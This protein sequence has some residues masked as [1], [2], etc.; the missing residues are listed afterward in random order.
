MNKITIETYLNSLGSTL[1]DNGAEAKIDVL[2][3]AALMLGFNAWSDCGDVDASWEPDAIFDI[4]PAMAYSGGPAGWL[5][6]SVSNIILP[7][8]QWG[9]ALKYGGLTVRLPTAAFCAAMLYSKLTYEPEYSDDSRWPLGKAALQIACLCH[10]M[11]WSVDD[12]KENIQPWHSPSP[13][14]DIS[15]ERVQYYIN[16]PVFINTNSQQIEKYGT[17]QERDIVC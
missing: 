15:L 17:L 7:N 10:A 2:G 6:N 4:A 12:L 8:P 5:N 13:K 3:S 16:N 9:A 14:G 11:K 1:S